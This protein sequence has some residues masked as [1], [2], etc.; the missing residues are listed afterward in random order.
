M[1]LLWAPPSRD[2]LQE[3]L[4]AAQPADAVV[5]FMGLSPRLEGEE[6][7]VP[8]DR[9]QGGDRLTLSLPPVQEKLIE[10]I[11]ALGKPTVLVLLSGSALAV[12]WADQHVPAV[13]Q[14]W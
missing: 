8:V 9:L 14:A 3:A 13:V 11:H 12:N 4:A 2:L 10:A 1:T 6:M 5:M 7:E